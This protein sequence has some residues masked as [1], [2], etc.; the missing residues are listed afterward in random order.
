MS[1]KGTHQELAYLILPLVARTETIQDL[2]TVNK[3]FHR[4]LLPL[5]YEHVN[6]VDVQQAMSFLLSVVELD[7]LHKV[8]VMQIS[9]DLER[10]DC[11]VGDG[12]EAD[13]G[14]ESERSEDEGSEDDEGSDSEAEVEVRGRVERG[15]ELWRLLRKALPNM[16]NLAT[17]QLVYNHLDNNVLLRFKHFQIP[18]PPQLANLF[19]IPSEWEEGSRDGDEND[20][21][22]VLQ[23]SILSISTCCYTV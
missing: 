10:W 20:N 22:C 16:T 15:K 17:L 18:S 3:T 19:L 11:V 13:E 4:I 9:F 5:M 8:K 23:S 7:M 2:I 6:L 21:V 1:S 14:S 12:E